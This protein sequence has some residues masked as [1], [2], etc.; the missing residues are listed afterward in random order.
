MRAH[1]RRQ[2]QQSELSV[3]WRAQ[4][5]GGKGWSHLITTPLL[6][7][8]RFSRAIKTNDS[9]GDKYLD[10]EYY[11]MFGAVDACMYGPIKSDVLYH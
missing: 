10:K 5:G 8:T 4:G 11:M 1:E 2:Q 7:P 6:L 3:R 9:D